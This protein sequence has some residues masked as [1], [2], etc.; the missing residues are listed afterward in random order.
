MV[1]IVGFLLSFDSAV[2]FPLLFMAAC[3]RWAQTSQTFKL[4]ISAQPMKENANERCPA[5][6][7]SHDKPKLEKPMHGEPPHANCGLRAPRSFIAAEW[8]VQFARSVLCG[9]KKSALRHQPRSLALFSCQ[10]EEAEVRR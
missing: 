4:G 1:H 10:S 2:P 5:W 3:S 7:Q 6:K 9:R 8:T